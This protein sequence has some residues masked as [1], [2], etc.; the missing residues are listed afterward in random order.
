MLYGAEQKRAEIGARIRGVLVPGVE[1]ADPGAP[2]GV[3][4]GQRGRGVRA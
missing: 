4:G 2:A 1:A 3:P